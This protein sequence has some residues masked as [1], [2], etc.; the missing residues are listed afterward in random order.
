MKKI[1]SVYIRLLVL[2]IPFSAVFIMLLLLTV[3]KYRISVISTKPHNNRSTTYFHDLDHDGSSEEIF[4]SQYL[5]GHF[6]VL[7][8]KGQSIKNEWPVLGSYLKLSRDVFHDINRDGNDEF[9]MFH[10]RNDSLF[11]SC[12][13]PVNSK[14]H[15]QN[16][17]IDKISIT[18]D[19]INS[20]PRVAGYFDVD[21]DGLDEIF[22][23]LTTG[24]RLQPRNMYFYNAGNESLVKA[25]TNYASLCTPV[26]KDLERDGKPE[27][28]VNTHAY[29]NSKTTD[30]FS[31]HYSWLMVFNHDLS[32]KFEP[33]ILGSFP[34]SSH[35]F[36]NNKL[37]T[38]ELIVLQQNKSDDPS[39]IAK[40]D[41]KGKKLASREVHIDDPQLRFKLFR[42]KYD[43]HLKVLFSDGDLYRL[44]DN[45]GL[46]YIRN[47]GPFAYNFKP[48][49][50]DIL[51]DGFPEWV[52]YNRERTG[53]NVYQQNLRSYVEISLHTELKLAFIGKI[54]GDSEG[55]NLAVETDSQLYKLK[56]EKSV[57]F[58]Y[59]YL[60]LL[61]TFSISF[62]LVYFVWLIS[63]VRRMRIRQN[64]NNLA[65]I[66]LKAVQNQIDPHFTFNLL[67]AFK[68][69][70]DEKD[71]QK[72]EYIFENYSELLKR[73]VLNGDKLQVS[74][75]EEL[76][77]VKSYI[78]LEAF[79]YE[80]SFDYKIVVSENIDL[81]IPI[82]KM[83]MHIYV[84]N[85]IKHGL[86]HKQGEKGML[87]IHIV[88]KNG[89]VDIEITDNGIGRAAAAEIRRFSS[90]K[91]LMLVDEM[92]NLYRSLYK[93]RIDTGIVDLENKRE[94]AGTRV[95][96]RIEK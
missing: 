70:I 46:D 65:E 88:E 64:K 89:F 57:F 94:P 39:Y 34:S 31:D 47:I 8:Y 6:G 50:I 37:V 53:I 3:N 56:Y 75:Q 78:E 90:G 28:L 61:L 18:G 14:F 49:E 68:N 74:L 52:F 9:V 76:D 23:A 35:I 83:L 69:L 59:L 92:T 22:F 44:K 95:N 84:E 36:A 11:L 33:V 1:K 45:L 24:F 54:T 87:T 13:D 96:I 32:Y 21:Q 2:S 7:V 77:F 79:R 80:G 40:F 29:G 63:D 43:G 86:R 55:A 27:I 48:G 16:V 30:R 12:L 81:K 72:A 51:K 85:A 5:D 58:Q 38:T 41:L 67:T 66:Q 19:T 71:S 73:T 10:Y 4:I 42:H 60:T 17:F 91:G 93:R 82:P 62:G 26:L 20:N 25:G 15:Y